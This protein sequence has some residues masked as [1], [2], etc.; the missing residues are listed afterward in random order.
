VD[1]RRAGPNEKRGHNEAHALAAAGGREAP[2]MLGTIMAEV[3]AI[4]AAEQHTIGLEQAS[5]TDFACFGPSRRAV[6]GD[7]LGLPRTPDRHRDRN[8]DGRDPTA[9]AMYA[10]SM[11]ISRA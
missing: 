6:G 1:N 4:P 8:R 11:K 7:P 2:H 10:P 5:L 3:A 9:R